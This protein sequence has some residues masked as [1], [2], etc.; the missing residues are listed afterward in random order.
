M[1]N[2]VTITFVVFV[3]GVVLVGV[4]VGARLAVGAVGGGR[5]GPARRG[6]GLNTPTV[7]YI[8]ITVN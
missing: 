2:K 7:L 5:V 3:G 8:R 6:C 4:G 1:K